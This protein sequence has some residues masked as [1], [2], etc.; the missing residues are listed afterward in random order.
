MSLPSHSLIPTLTFPHSSLTPLPH[1]TIPDLLSSHQCAGNEAEVAA[2]CEYLKEQ[3]ENLERRT[4]QKAQKLTEANQEQQFNTGV[5]DMDFWLANVRLCTNRQ[6]F[7]H[8]PHTGTGTTD[9]VADYHNS[10]HYKCLYD[11]CIASLNCL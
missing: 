5:K 4:Q 8:K 2:R 11:V 3:W 6:S 7:M 9:V 10:V 1:P